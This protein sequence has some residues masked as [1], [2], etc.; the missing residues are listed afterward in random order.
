MV[1]VVSDRAR[2]HLRWRGAWGGAFR[3]GLRWLGSGT[4]R[5]GSRARCP[6]RGGGPGAAA[7]TSALPVPPAICERFTG[8]L[9]PFHNQRRRKPFT[10]K[11]GFQY[12]RCGDP[13][14]CA[15]AVKDLKSIDPISG[16]VTWINVRGPQ[17]E[18][19]ISWRHTPR[20]R[21][22][23]LGDDAAFSWHIDR[24]APLGRRANCCCAASAH[25]W[26][27][28]SPVRREAC[29][30]HWSRGVRRRGSRIDGQRPRPLARYRR[31]I[32][33]GRRQAKARRQ[34]ARRQGQ[35]TGR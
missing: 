18:R 28:A 27:V 12:T 24:D 8:P 9:D 4:W 16:R 33:H 32:S 17:R 25:R 34:E 5:N 14:C 10:H 1:A 22:Q 19:W 7:G 11:P 15:R 26:A 21:G 30:R 29:A 35:K 20:S 13:I 6:C 2:A 23:C 3:G 31:H